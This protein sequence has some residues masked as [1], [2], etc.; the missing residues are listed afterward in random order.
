MHL[1]GY[2]PTV[3][4][5]VEAGE[6]F[7]SH[8]P[9]MPNRPEFFGH[10]YICNTDDEVVDEETCMLIGA[11]D[12]PLSECTAIIRRM[13][14][15]AV[16]AHI[17]RGSNG[18]LVNLGMMPLEPAFPVVEVSPELPIDP[19]AVADRM[20]LRSSDAHRLGNI[21]EP[22]FDLPVD[23]FSLGGLFERVRKD[24]KR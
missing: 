15:A 23:R 8:L 5:A 9:P 14:G 17:N 12:L 2:F 4:A 6:L 11:T 13:G 16:P 1:L 22:V 7:S 24:C 3:E 19:A 10:Q 18:L 20:T 21:Q